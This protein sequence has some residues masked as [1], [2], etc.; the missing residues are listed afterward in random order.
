VNGGH[1]TKLVARG[2]ADRTLARRKVAQLGAR[3]GDLVETPVHVRVAFGLV[4]VCSPLRKLR[5]VKAVCIGVLQGG[6][7][8]GGSPN[9]NP[10]GRHLALALLQ[11]FFA[12]KPCAEFRAFWPISEL[13]PQVRGAQT[14]IHVGVVRKR[15][16]IE[17]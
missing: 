10:S 15:G 8:R 3:R 13:S 11:S 12:R 14:Q 2:A 5:T 7:L 4:T 6:R 9:S 17:E 1:A 16:V